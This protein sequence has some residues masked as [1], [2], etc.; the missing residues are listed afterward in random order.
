MTKK[1]GTKEV[2]T[3]MQEKTLLFML[4]KKVLHY[5]VAITQHFL[6][7]QIIQL[8]YQDVSYFMVSAVAL[9]E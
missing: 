8:I 3:K 6:D 4:E 9:D 1:G 2:E 7:R 5:T